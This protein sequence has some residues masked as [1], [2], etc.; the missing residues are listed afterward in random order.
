MTTVF[1]DIDTQLDFL[2]P[3]GAL[4]VPG[5]ERIIPLLAALNRHAAAH[6][7]PL[8][9]TVDAHAEDDPE[10][11]SWPAHCVA[12]TLGQRKPEETR[13]PG[14]IVFEK[15]TL[16]AFEHPGFPAL[17]DR[18]D[19]GRCVVYGVVTEVCV[20]FAALGLLASGRRVEVVADAVK[21]FSAPDRDAF[22]AAFT[23]A[24]GVLTSSA[25]ILGL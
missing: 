5:A 21:E 4:Y 20:R 7:I 3:A 24:G 6:G 9:S 11:R 8:V 1:F 16:N 15:V 13:V 23:A 22:L 10:F 25:S 14:Q 18:L 17:L 2:L 12:G 19:A